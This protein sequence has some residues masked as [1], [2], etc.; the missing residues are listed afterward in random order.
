MHTCFS[1]SWAVKSLATTSWVIEVTANTIATGSSSYS[2]MATTVA[3]TL[4]VVA[5]SPSELVVPC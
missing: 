5:S 1:L 3:D 4:A 2:D